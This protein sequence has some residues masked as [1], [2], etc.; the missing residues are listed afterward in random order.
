MAGNPVGTGF[1]TGDPG[2]RRKSLDKKD[3]EVESARTTG[4]TAKHSATCPV[5]AL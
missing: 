4:R 1:D 2:L 5:P 3:P